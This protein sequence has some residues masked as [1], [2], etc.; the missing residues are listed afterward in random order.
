MIIFIPA[1]WW[2]GT[3]TFDRIVEMEKFVQT[4][5]HM[6]LPSELAPSI[7]LPHHAYGDAVKRAVQD[8]EALYDL[9]Q[10]ARGILSKKA[11]ARE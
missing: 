10:T 8:A 2:S 1:F 9:I 5:A 3:M 6:D 11:I 7:S 4:V